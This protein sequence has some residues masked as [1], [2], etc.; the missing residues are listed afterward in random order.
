[1]KRPPLK[2]YIRFYYIVNAVRSWFN[3][4]DMRQNPKVKTLTMTAL[5]AA[6]IFVLT[7]IIRVPI[8]G[9]GGY[10]NIGDAGVYVAAALLGGPAGM[11]AA[12]IG[13]ALADL[14]AGAALYILPTAIVKGLMGFVCGVLMKR[15]GFTRFLAAS[16]AG[17]AIMTGGYFVSDIVIASLNTA[18]VNISLAM[19]SLPPNIIQW[20]CGVAV[21][22]AFYPAV[23]RIKKN[24]SNQ[25]IA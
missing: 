4:N 3:K 12:A 23:T 14:S 11:I 25:D 5:M 2:N 6:A 13:S 8:G 19:A 17:G 20:V 10:V 1:M 9:S 7:F 21:A 18:A 22:A 15:A 16:V 24:L